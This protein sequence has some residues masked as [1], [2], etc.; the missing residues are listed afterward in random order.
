MKQIPTLL[1]SDVAEYVAEHPNVTIEQAYRD[2]RITDPTE[3]E[4]SAAAQSVSKHHTKIVTKNHEPVL[5]CPSCL[6]F[7]KSWKAANKHIVEQ[8]LEAMA[9]ERQL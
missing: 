8:M 6:I 3:Q 1:D 7:F 4:I 9:F 2:G 5:Y